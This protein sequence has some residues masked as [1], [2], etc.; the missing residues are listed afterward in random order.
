[1]FSAGHRR[2]ERRRV[3]IVDSMH[4]SCNHQIRISPIRFISEKATSTVQVLA[5]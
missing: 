3:I 1:M 5:D 2:T 4:V